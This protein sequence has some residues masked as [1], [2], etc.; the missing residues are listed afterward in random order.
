MLTN[1]I[2]IFILVTTCYANLNNGKY[3]ID[4]FILFLL[5]M[6]VLI[7]QHGE[8][9]EYKKFM[10]VVIYIMLFK[11]NGAFSDNEWT[12]IDCLTM[13]MFLLSIQIFYFEFILALYL[14]SIK[15][16]YFLP[17]PA[18]LMFYIFVILEHFLQFL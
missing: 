7:R 10:I 9:P 2:L 17:L 3:L 12:N 15:W 4:M 14:I 5:Y 1:S 16:Y 11:L 8:M 13:G 18:F 6:F